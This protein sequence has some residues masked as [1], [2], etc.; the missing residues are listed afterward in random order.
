MVWCLDSVV[1]LDQGQIAHTSCFLAEAV[2]ELPNI[3]SDTE[4][5]A[6][7]PVASSAACSSKAM[8]QLTNA[9]K[10]VSAR[11]QRLLRKLQSALLTLLNRSR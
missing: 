5:R 1:N 7:E 2:K 8:L 4:Q 11:K 6:R 9:N 3:V 10:E